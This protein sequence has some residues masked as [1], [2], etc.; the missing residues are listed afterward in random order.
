ME[1]FKRNLKVIVGTGTEA[2]TIT[3]PLSIR[4]VVVKDLKTGEKDYAQLTIFNLKKGTRDTLNTQ[5]EKIAIVGGYGTQEDVIFAGSLI[6]ATHKHEGTE[7]VSTLECGDGVEILDKA[8]VNKTYSKGFKLG[9]ILRD[10]AN[11]NSVDLGDIIGIDESVSLSRGK[12]FSTDMQSALDELGKANNFDWTMQDD[13][14]VVVNRGQYRTSGVRLISAR[15]GM[16]GSPEW[17]NT[18]SDNAKLVAQAGLKFKVTSL[19]IPSLKPADLILVESG[20]LQG[21]IGDYSYD[22]EKDSFRGE[23]VVSKVQHDLDNIQGNFIT[24]IEC[25]TTKDL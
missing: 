16:V 17:I 12:T 22:T 18:G 25:M 10:F 14:L 4:A 15:T 7:W 19:C 9:D 13:K 6:A 1:L 3:E 21:R 5:Y 24:Q 11:T 2:I 8:L 23:F 20:S